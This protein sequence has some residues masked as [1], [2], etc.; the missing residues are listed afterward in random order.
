MS[1]PP[2]V[3]PRRDAVRR[4]LAGLREGLSATAAA[5]GRAAPTLVAVTKAVDDEVARMVLDAGCQDLGEN[6]A[7][8]F[9]RRAKLFASE[10]LTPRWHYIGH[11]QRNKVRRVLEQAHVLHSVDSP[12]LA[13]AVVRITE[14]LGRPLDVFVQ[15][16]LTGEEEKHGFAAEQAADAVRMLAGSEHIKVR[17]LMAMGPLR[18]H[19]TPREVFQ[20][21]RELA[22][23]LEREVG[24]AFAADRCELS[25]GMS[26]DAPLAVELGSDLVRVGTALYRNVPEREE[27]TRGVLAQDPATTDPVNGPQAD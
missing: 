2:P 6:R 13:E 19:R 23:T 26:G 9:C 15:V 18:E 10:G 8:A 5:A 27:S 17:G 16:N 7:D 1:G 3:D 20:H 4:N 24:E 11:L 22:R 14:E 12:R 21:A 25:M